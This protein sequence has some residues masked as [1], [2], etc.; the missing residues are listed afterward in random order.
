MN[1]INPNLK[2]LS[3]LISMN[4]F[5]DW[6]F[7]SNSN[8]LTNQNPVN[9]FVQQNIGLTSIPNYYYNCPA[10]VQYWSNLNQ[11][12]NLNNNWSYLFTNLL[13]T[14]Y[15]LFENVIPYD[16]T[17]TTYTIQPIYSNADTQY[18]TI[19]VP[20]VLKQIS[21]YFGLYQNRLLQYMMLMVK[22]LAQ[23]NVMNGGYTNTYQYNVNSGSASQNNNYDVNSFNP[24]AN[25]TTLTINPINV[26]N[27]NYGNNLNQTFSITSGE[28]AITINGA[29]YNNHASANAS[30][31]N[32]FATNNATNLQNF[33]NVGTGD[34]LT[35]LRPFIKKI[36]SLFWSLGN[37]EYPDNINWGFNIW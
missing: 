1:Q 33:A 16:Q 31:S 17:T 11:F 12:S 21:S 3:Q 13:G 26:T 24:V 19:E 9:I 22:Y 32:Q 4:D 28:P 10:L 2:T 5:C 23:I 25:N 34:G 29:N 27:G 20:N 18:L 37:D 6:F 7:N 8:L 14:I 35:I 15:Q 30:N 36:S